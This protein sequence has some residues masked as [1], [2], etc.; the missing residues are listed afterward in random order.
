[1]PGAKKIGKVSFPSQES[2]LK[3]PLATTRDPGKPTFSPTAGHLQR[4]W[5]AEDW[6]DKNLKK[7]VDESRSTD[8]RM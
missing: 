6:I 1:M 8:G 3:R 5:G 4:G 7:K 2:A